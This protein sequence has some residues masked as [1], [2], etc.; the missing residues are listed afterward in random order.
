MVNNQGIMHLAGVKG[1]EPVCRNRRAHMSTTEDCFRQEPK[2][3]KRCAA[4]LAQRDAKKA[5]KNAYGETITAEMVADDP[6]LPKPYPFQDGV[7]ILVNKFTSRIDGGY[8]VKNGSQ[9]GR[10]WGT[11]ELARFVEQNPLTKVSISTT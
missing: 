8:Q 2:Q 11:R 9:C 5:A 1:G 4:K 3:C 7:I 10:Y 6:T